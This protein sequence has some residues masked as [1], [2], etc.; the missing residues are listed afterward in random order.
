[1]QKGKRYLRDYL[2]DARIMQKKVS[3]RPLTENEK[4]VMRRL[5]RMSTEMGVMQFEACVAIEMLNSMG[6]DFR[7]LAKNIAGI[8]DSIGKQRSLIRATRASMPFLKPSPDDARNINDMIVSVSSRI[9]RLSGSD[10]PENIRIT[11][12]HDYVALVGDDGLVRDYRSLYPGAGRIHRGDGR[13]TAYCRKVMETLSDAGL[14]GR[15]IERGGRLMALCPKI[16]VD[17]KEEA[18]RRKEEALER[19]EAAERLSEGLSL[20][21]DCI[22]ELR[23]NQ[24]LGLQARTMKGVINWWARETFATESTWEERGRSAWVVLICYKKN[25]RVGERFMYRY[26]NEK[27]GPHPFL[28]EAKLF[29]DRKSAEAIAEKVMA[30]HPKWACAPISLAGEY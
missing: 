6:A 25:T 30:E 21:H 19:A 2:D 27:W 16:D 15:Y 14:D 23:W 10:I 4:A 24:S 13:I 22:L 9:K 7:P 28:T 12:L 3:E 17:R 11:P 20:F 8:S 26:F 5:D 1:M 29:A 18:S